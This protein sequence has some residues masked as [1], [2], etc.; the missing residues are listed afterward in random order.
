ME[1]NLNYEKIDEAISLFGPIRSKQRSAMKISI[2]LALLGGLFVYFAATFLVSKFIPELD[3]LASLLGLVSVGGVG[4]MAFNGLRKKNFKEEFRNGVV[5]SVVDL[6]E[7]NWIDVTD[8]SEEKGIEQSF[9]KSLLYAQELASFTVIDLFESEN[10]LLGNLSTK[11]KMNNKSRPHFDGLFGVVT[12][13]SEYKGTHYIVTEQE[14]TPFDFSFGKK[15]SIQ[16]FIFPKNKDI[17]YLE[18]N[19]FEKHLKIKTDDQIEAREILSPNV[20]SELYVLWKEQKQY[21]RLCITENKLYFTIAVPG[22]FTQG[23]HNNTERS[24]R[25]ARKD[26][27]LLRWVEELV[28]VFS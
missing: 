25:R 14:S 2:A 23:V 22:A 19:D 8:N 1:N 18:W 27:E 16:D 5:K 11:C 24:R 3:N 21:V 15:T 12:L 6:G 20:M 10:V 9:R 4:K 13:P 28:E 17:A 7:R 26:A